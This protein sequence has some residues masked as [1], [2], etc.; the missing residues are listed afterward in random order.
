MS[1]ILAFLEVT[2]A[3]RGYKKF[4]EPIAEVIK[5]PRPHTYLKASDLPDRWDWRDVN[6]TNYCGKVLTQQ[7]PNVCGSCWAEA[8]TGALSDRFTIATQGKLRVALSPQALLNFNQL[9]TGG[10]C[11][12]GDDL[13]AYEF[14]HK[15]GIADDT[16]QVF[17]GLDAAHGFEVNGFTDADDIR[18]HQ[19]YLCEWNGLCG[20][21]PK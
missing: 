12:G 14:A 9:L 17:V 3:R 18:S 11:N 1:C 10:T 15:H 7:S 4:P 21:A 16:C 5:T 20:F 2:S 6:G 19:C 13:K 8:A